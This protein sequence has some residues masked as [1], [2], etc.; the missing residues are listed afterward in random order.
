MCLIAI[1]NK[2]VP[3]NL[4]FYKGLA[5]SYHL[6]N[7]D[8]AGF[9]IKRKNDKYII[10]EKGFFDLASLINAIKKYNVTT[11]DILVVHL[12]KVSAGK[13]SV[14]N[15]HPFVMD[16]NRSNLNRSFGKT[17]KGVLFH[18]GTFHGFSTH[19]SRTSDTYEYVRNFAGVP[20]YTTF[21]KSVLTIKNEVRR[22]EIEK[23]LFS[24]NKVVVL[25][26]I[27]SLMIMNKDMF[28]E[29]RNG[30]IF[31][32]DSYHP[33]TIRRDQIASRNKTFAY[34]DGYGY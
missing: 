6:R 29:D 7:K 11:D 3:I 27:K 25:H 24:E 28:L 1:K 19:Y 9:A 12:R 10:F 15:C 22:R 13:I 30:F 21:L 34:V 16:I 23:K 4:E 26:P 8:G 33:F 31:S 20:A 17:K 32:N 5:R 14:I 2:G 18:N